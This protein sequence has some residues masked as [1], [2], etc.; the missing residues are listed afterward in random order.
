[1]VTVSCVPDKVRI[2]CVIPLFN[3][4]DLPSLFA[5]YRSISLLL[6][7]SK[8]LERVVRNFTKRLLTHIGYFVP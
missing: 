5:N 4:G 1:M 2:A 3:A 6:S 7:F 8:F